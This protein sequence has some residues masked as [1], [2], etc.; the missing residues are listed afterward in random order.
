MSA[1]TPTLNLLA[2]QN[3]A[4]L[5]ELAKPDALRSA[6]ELARAINRDKSNV[7]KTLNVLKVEG[8]VLSEPLRL[9]TE[10][11]N[12]LTM[13]DRAQSPADEPGLSA[14]DPL[15]LSL[16]HAQI[17][18]DPDNARE[19]WNSDEARMAL[20]ALRMDIVEHGQHQNLLVRVMT[21]EEVDAA[22]LSDTAIAETVTKGLPL[23]RL[24]AGER[25]WRAIGEAIDEDDWAMDRT[26]ACRLIETDVLGLRIAALSENLQRR[27]LNP[28]EKAKG[29]EALAEAGL[30]NA[31]IADRFGKT[32][33]HVQQ[34]RRF[35]QLDEA[36]QQRMT[37]SRD[38]PRRLGVKE[39]RQKLAAR[40]A[41]SATI[42]L[43]PMTRLAWIEISHA[44]Y[45]E[46]EYRNLWNM[47]T[48]GPGAGQTPEG[49]RLEDLNFVVFYPMAT[50]GPG[51]GRFHARRG[52]G[53]INPV[54][55][56]PFPAEL[57]GEKA[58]QD[59]ALR[60]EQ[61]AALGDAA[62][63]WPENDV[64]YATPWLADIGDLTPEGEELRSAAQAESEA[65]DEA[66]RQRADAIAARDEA[67]ANARQRHLRLMAVA[68]SRPEAGRPE[69]ITDIAADLDRP[70]P[71][72]MLP[73]S[74]IVAANGKFVK[75]RAGYSYGPP[76]DHELAI[77]QMIVVAANVSG[78]VATPA[79]EDDVEDVEPDQDNDASIPEPDPSEFTDDDDTDPV[80]D[81]I[82]AFVEAE[83][84]D[85]EADA[86]GV[87]DHHTASAPGEPA[88]PI[89]KSITPDFMV[90]LE[91]G[92]KFK[93]LKRHLRVKYDLTP[94]AY[95]E[96]WG[97]P[98][99]YPMVAPNYA[100]ARYD[101]A[102]QMG[103][104]QPEQAAQT[105]E[106]NA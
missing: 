98:R 10:G 69:E 6:A 45:N 29:F 1:V 85:E 56:P 67:W 34:H 73:S 52:N 48:V 70:L 44:A 39:A 26:I 106:A 57:F 101:L 92:R 82:E 64:A 46:G 24:V 7:N 15:N 99:D 86:G 65:Q 66:A 17:L 102:R 58:L 12:Q 88:V 33:E 28:I 84:E 61:M 105:E 74:V 20:M 9:T 23:Y 91:D 18:P 42:E 96:K 79:I 80:E 97:L 21:A 94:E 87:M 14:G 8:L 3:A 19:D 36:D 72:R 22:A 81:A 77:N 103:V 11:Q 25:R 55:A 32:P 71:W 104:G 16:V 83:L 100:K 63:V 54:V 68:Q 78:G 43:D 40:D 51:A 60:A 4:L 90:C 41:A 37:L 75:E 62:P 31:D 5:R 27:D 35:L 50:N 53:A 89:R 2:V 59:A 13:L 93:S 76:S 49:A 30:S 47:V 38:D 95:R